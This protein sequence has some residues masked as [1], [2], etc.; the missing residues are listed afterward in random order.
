MAKSNRRF[1]SWQ[2]TRHGRG[3][4]DISGQYTILD[5]TVAKCPI[6]AV[7]CE[8][9][10]TVER[11]FGTP[12]KFLWCSHCSGTHH[13]DRLNK[14]ADKRSTSIQAVYDHVWQWLS[15]HAEEIFELEVPRMIH[16]SGGRLG[17]S[18]HVKGRPFI[19]QDLHPEFLAYLETP[20]AIKKAHDVYL[21][22]SRDDYE[23]YLYAAARAFGFS[24]QQID[25]YGILPLGVRRKHKQ[26]KGNTLPPNG[27]T[28]R[29]NRKAIAA[30]LE[31]LPEQ[32]TRFWGVETAR[33][34]ITDLASDKTK[35][36]MTD[37]QADELKKKCDLLC[38]CG[39][40]IK[41]GRLNPYNH[42]E[43]CGYRQAIIANKTLLSIFEGD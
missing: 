8:Q 19:S 31:A 15:R 32:L 23:T 6:C 25:D 16:K 35:T 36:L 11:A 17:S 2:L 40:T 10:L 29:L 37:A 33:K 9:R 43:Q 21:V 1:N 5:T 12:S 30:F 41:R 38:D 3:V 13:W 20:E 4:I 18:R 26:G 39:T 22:M 42:S 14:Q 27:V 24:R 28:K 7:V 34:Q